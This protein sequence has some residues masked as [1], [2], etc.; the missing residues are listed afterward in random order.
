MLE[1]LKTSAADNRYNTD[2]MLEI[3]DAIYDYYEDHGDLEVDT[4]SDE[5]D[6]DVEALID[7][8]TRILV[9]PGRPYSRDD[10][11]AAVKEEIN[12]ELSLI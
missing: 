7:A 3:I 8:V 4:D 1:K 11:A 9:R 2:D 10:I 12:Y 6:E 5:N